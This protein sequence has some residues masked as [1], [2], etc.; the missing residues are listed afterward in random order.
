MKIR[1]AKG[2]TL[3]EQRETIF[4]NTAGSGNVPFT[5]ALVVAATTTLQLHS[6]LTTHF[7]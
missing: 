2:F 3:I 7:F 5:A 1:N 4:Q 6:R